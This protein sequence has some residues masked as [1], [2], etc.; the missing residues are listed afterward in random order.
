M[1]EKITGSEADVYRFPELDSSR[2][3]TFV[4]GRGGGVSRYP[5]ESLNTDYSGKDDT[6]NVGENINRIK[7][8]V[9]IERIWTPRQVHGAN[10][11]VV[12]DTQAPLIDADAV[13]LSTAGIAVAVRTADCLPV[14]LADP[15]LNVVAVI[16]AGRRGSEM[17][18]TAKTVELMAQRFGSKPERVLAGLGPCIGECCYEVDDVT[19]MNFHKSCGGEKGVMLDIVSANKRQLIMVGVAPK[20]IFNSGICVSCEN[21]K[22]FSY[23]KERNNT[24]RFLT[25]IAILPEY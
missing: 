17:G 12:D 18:V 11:A 5:Y 25:G 13:I 3:R 1:I 6:A 16:H 24:G 21:S 4:S 8:A 20:N 2:L 10:V 15:V 23:R 22:F 14:L 19:A 9:G 7:K